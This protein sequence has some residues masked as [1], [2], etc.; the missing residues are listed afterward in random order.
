MVAGND[1]SAG[2]PAVGVNNLARTNRAGWSLYFCAG[3]ALSIFR[4]NIRDVLAIP[5]KSP[6]QDHLVA[7]HRGVVGFLLVQIIKHRQMGEEN[8]PFSNHQHVVSGR[9]I[10]LFQSAVLL[11]CAG[12]PG[13]EK[14]GKEA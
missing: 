2:A 4:V 11:R 14:E 5:N 8:S 7:M 10:T 6:L 1:L 9:R 3:V 13:N 12:T